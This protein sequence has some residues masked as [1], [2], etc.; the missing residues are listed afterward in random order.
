MLLLPD[1]SRYDRE[2]KSYTQEVDEIGGA[3]HNA[4]VE[5]P[6]AVVEWLAGKLH[7]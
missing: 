2:L 7:V 6:E 3:G 4:H 5:K 1:T